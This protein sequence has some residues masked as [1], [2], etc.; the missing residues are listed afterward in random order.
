MIIRGRRIKERKKTT[1]FLFQIKKKI[2]YEISKLC[3]I[4]F[5]NNEK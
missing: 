3:N 1:E 2:L 4:L 5:Q